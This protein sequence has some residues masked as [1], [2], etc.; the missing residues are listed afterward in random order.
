MV[1]VVAAT[2][3]SFL[4]LIQISAILWIGSFF[5]FTVWYGRHLADTLSRLFLTCAQIRRYE[6]GNPMTGET[7]W[8]GPDRVK[9][10]RCLADNATPPKGQRCASRHPE[11]DPQDSADHP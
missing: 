9:A 8:S 2:S 7:K 5:L 3:G 10:R 4:A 1:R 6:L 11:A